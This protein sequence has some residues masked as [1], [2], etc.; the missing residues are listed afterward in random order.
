VANCAICE[1]QL[2]SAKRHRFFC[3]SACK[4]KAHRRRLPP[5]RLRVV[6]HVNNERAKKWRLANPERALEL[7][8]RWQAANRA[9]TRAAARRFLAQHPGYTRL[10]TL[11]K[12]GLSPAEYDAMLAAQAGLCAA[13]GG[14]E[15]SLHPKTGKP[16]RLSVDHCHATGRVRGLLCKACNFAIGH[17]ADDPERLIAAAE[18]L[19]R[20]RS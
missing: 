14:A 16:K 9:K 17:A 2:P 5:E 18:Y 11:R 12:Y 8:R 3:S 15:T 19:R 6:R 1:V 7:N 20:H 4:Q 13:C 10:R